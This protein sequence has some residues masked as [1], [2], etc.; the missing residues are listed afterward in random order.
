MRTSR[1]ALLAVAVAVPALACGGKIAPLGQAE[2]AGDAG[3]APDAGAEDD[4]GA[5]SPDAGPMV[6]DVFPTSGPNS[7]GTRVTITGS[8]FDAE[9]GTQITFAGFPAADVACD[10]TVRCVATSPY[11]GYSAVAETVDVQATVGGVLGADGSRSSPA[12][13]R[14]RF[15]F[16]AGP[17][18]TEGLVCS[19]FFFPQL[20]LT[21][22]EAVAFY[23]Y[24]RTSDQELVATATTYSITTNDVGA[25]VA[26]CYGDPSSSSCTPYS[27]FEAQLGYCGDPSF[28]FVCERWLG[29]VCGVD[30]HGQPVC[31]N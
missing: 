13:P 30:G 12:R 3:E 25:A 21:C 15:T 8:G 5:S 22:S 2:D 10:S 17:S 16:T 11:A 18:C 28:C 9:G 24:A 7:G 26:V 19:G 23:L 29:G 4:A 27:T 6:D 31:A 20:V 14:D 1:H